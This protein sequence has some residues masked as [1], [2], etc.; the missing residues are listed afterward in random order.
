[1]VQPVH[2]AFCLFERDRNSPYAMALA[3]TYSSIRQRTSAALHVH[4][5]CD[6]SV[7]LRTRRRLQRC[8]APGDG[9]EWIEAGQVPEAASFAR[10]MDGRFSPAIIWRVWLPD[11]LSHLDR[12]LLLDCDL[13]VL[14]DIQRLWQ[15]DLGEMALSAFQGGKQHP[16]AYYQ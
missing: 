14:L 13:Q 1:M 7:R 8:L 15:I 2:L 4:V 16:E 11:Y 6:H 12:C 3:A 9:L 10:R 5:I